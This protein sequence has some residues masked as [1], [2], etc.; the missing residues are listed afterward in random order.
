MKNKYL[1]QCKIGLFIVLISIFIFLC[2]KKP[3]ENV[4]NKK[5]PFV[6]VWTCKISPLFG[7][8]DT[9]TITL[10]IKEDNRYALLLTEYP[11]DT[12]FSSIGKWTQK[13]DSLILTGLECKYLD[14]LPIIDT[15]AKL[16]DSVCNK[17]LSLLLPLPEEKVWNI[18]TAELSFVLYSFP[19]SKEIVDMI[20]SLIPVIPLTKEE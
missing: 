3:T 4:E 19:V 6:S 15:L 20:P 9:L 5:P 12:L 17:S 14:T 8:T 18:P 7:L 11:K 16:P 10:D 2:N 1:K 13:N